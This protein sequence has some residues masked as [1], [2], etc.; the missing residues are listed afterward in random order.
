[1]GWIY[2]KSNSNSLK[3]SKEKD[4]VIKIYSAKN[5][6]NIVLTI[7]DNGI[8]IPKEDIGRIFEKGFTG[9]NGR[10]NIKKEK[11]I[12]KDNST[13][14]NI[15]KKATG[16]GLYLCKNLCDKLDIGIRCESEEGRYTRMI[17]TFPD[18]DYAKL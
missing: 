5:K 7:E 1:M 10:R 15:S 12:R 17:F 8:G 9:S 6:S 18:S 3:Y 14:Y 13:D 4:S 11:D 16:I 2:I